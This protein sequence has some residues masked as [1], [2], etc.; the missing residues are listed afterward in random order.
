MYQLAAA[1]LMLRSSGALDL[2]GILGA[3]SL[4]TLNGASQSI[5][6][7]QTLLK[8]KRRRPRQNFLQ[9]SITEMHRF[10][11]GLESTRRQ[12]GGKLSF[13]SKQSFACEQRKL[14]DPVSDEIRHREKQ[15]AS[16]Q[17]SRIFAKI[18]PN[19]NIIIVYY[20]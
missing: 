8:I 6:R 17:V 18:T 16:T 11:L 7:I 2:E 15:R 5:C 13:V 1:K 14:G 20:V 10:K 3:I 9:F 12:Q 19:S 4:C